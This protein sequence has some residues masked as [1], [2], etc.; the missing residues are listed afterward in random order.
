MTNFIDIDGSSSDVTDFM[1]SDMK[2]DG[3]SVAEAN[4]T[5]AIFM[6]GASGSGCKRWRIENVW[7]A[8]WP[9]LGINAEQSCQSGN[10]S[11]CRFS[12]IG[13]GASG[14]KSFGAIHLGSTTTQNTLDIDIFGN[15]FNGIITNASGSSGVHGVVVVNSG[16]KRIRVRGNTFNNCCQSI[17]KR[18]IG[19]L[20]ETVTDSIIDSNNIDTCGGKAIELLESTITQPTNTVVSNNTLRNWGTT[21]ADGQRDATGYKHS[22]P[23]E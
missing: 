5:R 15:E 4:N 9:V 3:N 17:S 1:I 7:F 12:E 20:D 16:A 10:V 11:N 8:D 22:Q 18:V 6:Q 2:I 13:D 14:S 23:P 21:G 19:L